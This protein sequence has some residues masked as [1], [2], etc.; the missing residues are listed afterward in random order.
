MLRRIQHLGPWL[1]CLF[2][3]AQIGGVTRLVYVDALH[4]YGHVDSS[5]VATALVNQAQPQPHQHPP[6]THDEHDQCCALHHGLVGM[7]PDSVE[8]AR[9]I[10]VNSIFELARPTLVSANPARL[11]RP[12]RA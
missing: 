9:P 1:F 6:G 10:A 5:A 2:L 8:Q 4:E 3:V 11:D 7:L 12:P